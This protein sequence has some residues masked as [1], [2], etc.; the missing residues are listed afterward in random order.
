MHS[1]TSDLLQFDLEMRPSTLV[2]A[3]LA[4]I[5]VALLS[6]IPGV[7]TMNRLDLAEVVRE[8]AI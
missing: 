2:L 3:A 4:M 5:V 8:R 6:V 1:Y 7:R